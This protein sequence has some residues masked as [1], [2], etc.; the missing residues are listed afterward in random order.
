M[1][2]RNIIF[3]V[4]LL[5]TCTATT[6]RPQLNYTDKIWYTSPADAT[7]KDVLDSW[8][9]DP[10]W[11][12]ALPVGNGF[13]G[14]MVF[15]DVNQER[16][17]LNEKSLWSGSVAD[18]DNP[19]AAKYIPEIRKLLFAGKYKEATELTNKTQ[20]CKGKGSGH[21]NGAKVPFGC[22]Q[23][24]GDLMMDFGKKSSY[25][26]YY[27][28]L[29]LITGIA[30]TRYEQD[31]VKYQRTVFCSYPDKAL[32]IRLTANK[33]N[34]LSFRMTL[35]RP[36]RFKT[37]AENNRLI[38]SGILDDGK[39]GD[40]M[41]Y[42]TYAVPQ[43]T[44]GTLKTDRNTLQVIKATSVTIILTAATNYRLNYPDYT[45]A[46]FE[47]ELD[48][49]TQNA[50]AKNYELLRQRHTND[51]SSFMKRSALRLNNSTNNVPT[52][53]LMA[54]NTQ[55]QKEASLYSLYYQYGRYLLLSSSR[56][57][58]LPANLQGIWA[59]KIQT[60]WNGD[61]HTNI[62][63]QM[64]YWPA[65]VTNL[66]ECHNQL[67][68]LVLS[69]L[70]PG[71]RTAKTQYQMNGWVLHPITNVWGYTSPGEHPSWGMH[72]GGGGWIC[73]HLWQHYAFTKD[74]AYLA[75]VFP[76]LKEA[77]RF[78]LD[79]LVKDPKTGK[80]VSGP[81]SSPENS[82]YAPDGI[83]A[84]I[85][86]GPAHDQEVI[87]ELFS[88]TLKAAEILNINDPRFIEKLIEAKGNLARPQIGSDGRLQEWAEEFKEADVR[89]RHLS[90]LYAFYPG[91]EIT[92]S[93]TPELAEAVKKSLLA[94]GGAGVG[95]T[96]A[97][98]IALWARLKDGDRA[99]KL[100]N[101]Q[102]RPS[103]EMDTKNNDGG[104]TYYN[105]FCAGPPFQIDGNLGVVGGM[106]EMLLQSHESFISLLPALP[107]A[108]KDG[109]ITGLV[110][111]GGLVIDL[112]WKNHQLESASITAKNGGE[113]QLKYKDKVSVHYLKPNEKVML[114]NFK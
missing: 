13:L 73:Q 2:N 49:T 12:K 109:S 22:Y 32:V 42:K 15:G 92:V 43:L 36:E 55:N 29:D 39:G 98:K 31:G 68:D 18:N 38:M 21:G 100:L 34:S 1:N 65:E 67:S 8:K 47:S 111:R 30:L 79:W 85:S 113:Y 70:E 26:N 90:H 81:S 97:W 75:K 99:L 7:A 112:I 101:T 62:N 6:V 41:H 10:E 103:F 89:H 56:K 51:F 44:G 102:L 3:T 40:G 82:F 16:I 48:A 59:N 105:L 87:F 14:A 23:T 63:V 66:S 72:V 93:E 25:K 11:L 114:T 88:N 33:P 58:S 17:Q 28:E 45:N 71:K 54:R 78:F 80:L 91:N 4:I 53:E 61:Y 83:R 74:T 46:N 107:T 20:V 9:S 86:M 95:W 35:N 5:L 96:Y 19:E 106:A 24:L 104:G 57:G 52:N 69:L 76:V 50:T 110:A 37:R 84:S 60:P 108:W 64:N 94:R 77:S 27:R